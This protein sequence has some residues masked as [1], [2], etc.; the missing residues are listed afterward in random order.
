M[1]NNINI[2]ICCGSAL[3]VATA[4]AGGAQRAEL[5]SCLYF[6]GLTPSLGSVRAASGYGIPVMAM[7]R[8]REGDFCYNTLE[9]KVMLEDAAL[10][11]ENGASG[12]VFGALTDGGEI[13]VGLCRELAAISAGREMVFH[14]AFDLLQHNWQ[15]SLSILIDIGITRVLTSGFEKTAILGAQKII[16]MA[17]FASGA[18][19]I[20]PGGG[21]RAENISAFCTLTGCKWVHTSAGQLWMPDTGEELS[22]KISF[23][24][25]Q[26]AKRGHGLVSEDAVRKITKEVRGK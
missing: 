5:S 21:I 7:I 11:L 16:E 10:M 9:K 8:P 17:E 19:E 12:I 22:D 14:R 13:D 6:G 23:T 3:D 4:A 26:P 25:S 1:D 2:E 24:P 20:L 15:K 18:I